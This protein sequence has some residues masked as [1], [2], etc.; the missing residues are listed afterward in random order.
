MAAQRARAHTGLLADSPHPGRIDP[1]E[2]GARAPWAID[3]RLPGARSP[4]A[5]AALASLGI[6]AARRGDR[7]QALALLR[8]ALALQRELFGDRHQSVAA[9]MLNLSTALP[10]SE[11]DEQRLLLSDAIA[12]LREDPAAPRGTIRLA[13]ALRNLALVDYRSGRADEARA[14]L[15]ESLDVG[16]VA[17]GDGHPTVAGT[18]VLLGILLIGT[19]ESGEAVPLIEAAL[20]TLRRVSPAADGQLVTALGRLAALYDADGRPADAERLRQEAQVLQSRL[21]G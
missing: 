17:G 8:E 21:D 16:L 10:S 1:P 2:V 13:T 19:P 15:R 6:G 3:P 14:L 4:R 12:V 5:A 7:E 11:V 18:R 9:T 20:P